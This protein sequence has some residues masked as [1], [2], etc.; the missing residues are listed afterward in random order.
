MLSSTLL[1][2]LLAFVSVVNGA[3]LSESW[4]ML[5]SD[6]PS[7][8]K[9]VDIPRNL[10]LCFGIQYSTMRLPNLLEHETL[11]EVTQQAAPW[12]PL[13]RLNCH[14]DT[15]LFLCS[16]F[17]PVCLTTMDKE[18]YPCRSLCQA[19]QNGCEGRMQQYGFP[20]PEML[21][22][23]KYPVEN[24]MC[25]Q[26]VAN[27]RN[28]TCQSCSQVSTYE[29]ILDHFCRSQIV[30]KAKVRSVKDSHLDVRRARSLKRGDRRR[31]VMRNTSIFFSD[32]SN[33]SC[34][35]E[36]VNGEREDNQK[37]FLVM[38]NQNPSGEYVA[39]LILPWKKEKQFKRAVRM[40][41]KLNCQSLG[42]EIRERAVRDPASFEKRPSRHDRYLF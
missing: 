34:P 38:A 16:L 37:G 14:P 13:L 30:L 7:T 39:N 18:I 19:V 15:Q 9:C 42:R 41:R 26:P 3:Y 11:G 27:Y 23:N 22:C 8:P 35:C 31:S 12:I 29:N 5:T 33:R 40:F 2:V 10:S 21:N 4:A 25:I 1:P 36:T 32:G 17:A 28:Q 20:W 24:D 6:R